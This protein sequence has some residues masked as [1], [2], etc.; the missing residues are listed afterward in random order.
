M[1]QSWSEFACHSMNLDTSV[2]LESIS[3]SPDTHSLGL[4]FS[5]PPVA[6]GAATVWACGTSR[7]QRRSEM[8]KRNILSQGGRRSDATSQTKYKWYH[9]EL[10]AKKMNRN[11]I[12]DY[13]SFWL[14]FETY[15]NQKNNER[16]EPSNPKVKAAKQTPKPQSSLTLSSG[17]KNANP[18]QWYELL[19]KK[20]KEQDNEKKRKEKRVNI[21][22]CIIFR[23][24]RHCKPLKFR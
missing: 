15:L 11:K 16:V 21:F 10:F 4:C 20:E 8:I 18:E 22:E 12:D 3:G 1:R 13:F 14:N 7:C 5:V 17:E 24:L 19:H 6:T 23:F 9:F 2:H